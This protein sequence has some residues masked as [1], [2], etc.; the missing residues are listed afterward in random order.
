MEI[1]I[2]NARFFTES[3]IYCFHGFFLL[4][5]INYYVFAEYEDMFPYDG[6]LRNLSAKNAYTVE[7]IKEIHKLA[8][9]SKLEVIPLV[10]TFGHLEFALKHPEWSKLREIPNSPQA[11]CPSRNTT[12]EFITELVAQVSKI[13]YII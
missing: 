4:N 1:N 2:I 9:Q 3:T 6:I 12:L 10:Q 13:I 7:Q 11:V 8:E 5:I